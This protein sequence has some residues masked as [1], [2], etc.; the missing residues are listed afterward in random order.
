MFTYN[1][2]NTALLL[3]GGQGGGSREPIEDDHREIGKMARGKLVR[4]WAGD[5]P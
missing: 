3:K 4:V 2:V 5:Y 1:P